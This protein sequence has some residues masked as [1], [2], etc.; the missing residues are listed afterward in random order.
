MVG[1]IVT[2]TLVLEDKVWINCRDKYDE[3]A[4]YVEK[5]DKARSV[6]EGDKLWWQG[7]RAFWT[8]KK[9]KKSAD[10][11]KAGRDFEIVLER[12]GYSGVKRPDTSK[13]IG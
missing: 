8:P 10:G 7:G 1:G 9:F 13:V 5:T 11:G 6:S 12:R 4:I 2:E 3:C